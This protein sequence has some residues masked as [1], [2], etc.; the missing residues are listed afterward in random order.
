MIVKLSIQCD[1][2][3]NGRIDPGSEV[4]Y[5]YPQETVD[6]RWRDPFGG[7]FTDVEQ[8]MFQRVA[9]GAAQTVL[10][11]E[12]TKWENVVRCRLVAKFV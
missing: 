1:S 3:S 12:D 7:Y 8:A 2:D 9:T 4:A 11:H 5:V 6:G 10:L